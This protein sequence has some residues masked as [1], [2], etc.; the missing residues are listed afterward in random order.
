MRKYGYHRQPSSHID[1]LA[2]AGVRFDNYYA[3]DTPCLPSC[4]ALFSGRFGTCTGAIN[5]GGEY[6][7][8]PSQGAGRSFTSGLEG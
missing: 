7:D 3:T 2:K 5:H 1:A 6:A 4:P 8:L